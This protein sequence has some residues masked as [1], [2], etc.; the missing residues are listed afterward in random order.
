MP[1]DAI[2]KLIGQPEEKMGEYVTFQD[3]SKYSGAKTN[4]L[5]A[6]MTLSRIGG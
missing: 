4:L 6:F 2:N 5:E 1:K 3:I